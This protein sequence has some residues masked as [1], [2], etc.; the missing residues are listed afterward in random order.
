MNKLVPDYLLDFKTNLKILTFVG[1][2]AILFIVIYTPFE[3]SVWFK[4]NAH[5]HGLQFAYSLIVIAGTDSILLAARFLL[6]L[7]SKKFSINYVQYAFW[8]IGEILLVTI[9]YSL[10]NKLILQD[11][12]PILDIFRRAILFIP[13]ILFIPYL[14]SYL[15]L[16]LKEKDVKLANLLTHNTINA[17]TSPDMPQNQNEIINFHD[18]KGDLKLSVRQDCIYF[19]ESAD[20]YVKIYYAKNGKIVRHVLRNTLKDTEATLRPYGFARCHRSYVVNLQKIQIIRKEHEGFFIDFANEE[21]SEIPVSKTYVPEIT[22]L[23]VH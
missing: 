8:L 21:L 3:Y 22:Q 1:F 16:S 10:F 19:I 6:H 12:R 23:F 11:S 2:F 9:A 15:Y 13:T 5:S 7:V 4:S 14:I 17:E 20:N 18:E